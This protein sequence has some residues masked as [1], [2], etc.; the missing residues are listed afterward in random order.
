MCQNLK[1]QKLSFA[2]LALIIDKLQNSEIKRQLSL[3]LIS[4]LKSNK[5]DLILLD[6][7]FMNDNLELFE[8]E[9]IVKQLFNE[10][11]DLFQNTKEENY[12]LFDLIFLVSQ[13]IYKVQDSKDKVR[14]LDNQ[15]TIHYILW[16]HDMS[17]EYF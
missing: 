16:K 5:I 8:K 17:V 13:Q 7:K 9:I 4:F 1:I 14:L 11:T 12:Q 6:L 10:I 3:N 15:R 2:R